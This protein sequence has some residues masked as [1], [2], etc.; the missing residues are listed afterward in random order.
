MRRAILPGLLLA[1]VAPPAARADAPMTP[2]QVVAIYWYGKDF[3]QNIEF[4][5][6]L[7]NTLR[8]APAGTVEYHAE[9]LESNRFPGEEQA[10][11]L[12]DYLRAKYGNRGPDVVIAQSQVSL[13][14]VTA[15]QVFPNA[16]V[17]FHTL[18]RP[19]LPEHAD[20]P[21]MT[22]IVLAHVYR[23]TLNTALTLH[24]DTRQAFVIVQTPERNREYEM[25][26]REELRDVERAV[27]LTYLTDLTLDALLARVRGAPEHSLI[28]FVRY[29][30]DQPGR[31]IDPTDVLSVITAAARVP[32]YALAGSWLGRGSVGGY[33][34]DLEDVGARAGAVALR[35]LNG[36]RAQDIP[37]A[38][39][40]VVPRF[41]WRQLQRWGIREALLP[42][43]SVVLFR[44]V[45]LWQRYGRYVVVASVV[46]AGQTLL[47]AGLLVQHARR[48]RAEAALGRSEERSSAL[49][50][51]LPDMM[52]VL[53]SDGT[54]LDWHARDRGDLYAPPEMF[55]GKNVRDI[56]PEPLA[57]TFREAFARVLESGDPE[58]VNYTLTL[59]GEER[60]FEAQLVG[61]A[62]DR[63]L[64]IVRDVTDQHR[65]QLALRDKE[66]VL[67][68]S[69]KTNEDLAGRL[70]ASQ[71][72]ERQ[73]I[74]RD[75]H[76][77]LSQKLALLTLDISLLGRGLP[78]R[79]ELSTHLEEISRRA[80]DIAH[81]V[82]RISHELHPS[83]LQTL[84]LVLSMESICRETSDRFD[85][86]VDFVHAGIPA[87]VSPELA[88]CLYR[89]TQ[90]ALRNVVRHSGATRAFVHLSREND[91][92]FLQIADAGAGFVPERTGGMGLGLV[93]MYERVSFLRGQLVV[94]SAPGEGT[95]IGVRVPLHA[96][97]ETLNAAVE[98]T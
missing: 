89:V 50:R 80:S 82:H 88:L 49:L 21:G 64:S 15:Y 86:N 34:V 42:P 32:V 67:R 43:G 41:D 7:Q 56:M 10:V 59:H 23:N 8:R 60:H 5:R 9:Y 97:E 93:S 78:P 69:Y 28:L 90:E 26:V 48:R 71:E 25:A 63:I 30:Q 66:M 98:P 24:P 51:A 33:A 45:T 92:L 46:M 55:L 12:R 62:H 74:A 17:V 16:P 47:I 3:N 72:A 79:D 37:V 29:S 4:D 70:L 73:R 14:F 83:R 57:T 96:A 54:Y 19:R 52:F 68:A 1:L 20:G 94:Q 39:V 85:V 40:S 6:G 2:K 18:S 13:D 36:E 91:S 77:D 61:F 95:R 87:E 75:L 31:E 27:P 22:G 38:E 44:P 76:D 58:V 81:D 35:I 84:G 65:S 11:A 53:S